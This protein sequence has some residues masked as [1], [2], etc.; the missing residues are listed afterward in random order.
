MAY[1]AIDE[2]V[3]LGSMESVNPD[4]YKQAVLI[5]EQTN[6]DG[7]KPKKVHRKCEIKKVRKGYRW[8]D[9]MT[10]KFYSCLY[11]CG[12]NFDEIVKQINDP[13]IDRNIVKIKFKTEEKKNPLVVR[14]AMEGRYTIA[15]KELLQPKGDFV[16][17]ID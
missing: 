2:E 14:A 17:L 9:E 15:F 12:T 11:K 16:N 4:L 5:E 3:E 8:N 10:R 13:N 7:K 1:F 6:K